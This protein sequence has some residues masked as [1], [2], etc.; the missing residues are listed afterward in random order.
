MDRDGAEV[1]DFLNIRNQTRPT[2]KNM[3]FTLNG[4][5]VVR[6]LISSLEL[7]P[8]AG[9]ESRPKQIIVF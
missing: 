7:I 5:V 9:L 1:A 4:H 8:S 3:T 6:K 2:I